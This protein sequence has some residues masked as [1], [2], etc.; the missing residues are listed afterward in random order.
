MLHS[1]DEPRQGKVLRRGNGEDERPDRLSDLPEPVLECILGK[2][3]STRLAA[4]TS[5][6]SRAWKEIW[7]KVQRISLDSD[8]FL[9]QSKFARY[10]HG[11]ISGHS[12]S[13]VDLILYRDNN[14]PLDGRLLE[15][16]ISFAVSSGCRTLF[17]RVRI[18][19]TMQSSLL[20]PLSGTWFTSLELRGLF[21]DDGFGSC[22]FQN[23][24]FLRLENCLLPRSSSTKGG[25]VDDF[26]QLPSLESLHLW[27][28]AFEN[29]NTCLK[30][31]G[32]KLV[33]LEILDISCLKVEV[34][35]PNL[36]KY[37]ELEAMDPPRSYEFSVPSLIDSTVS[38][39]SGCF[40][41]MSGEQILSWCFS[42][43]NELHSTHKLT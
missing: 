8:E 43:F 28:C 16:V 33:E 31:T 40:D 19:G 3:E 12:G 34:V 5:V 22:T 14:S 23:L 18:G 35:A 41:N 29:T 13:S 37:Y 36:K 25:K 4:Q 26:T 15:E 24:V 6:L 2:L 21:L 32:P 27:G 39:R 1:P 11:V 17:I 7:C 10:V 30:I 38:V 20:T 42:I 9:D